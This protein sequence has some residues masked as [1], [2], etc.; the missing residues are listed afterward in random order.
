MPSASSGSVSSRV[1][2]LR[3]LMRLICTRVSCACFLILVHKS[4]FLLLISR[5]FA[6]ELHV[7]ILLAVNREFLILSFFVLLDGRLRGTF[8]SVASPIRSQY[9]IHV[10]LQFVNLT[11]LCFL[12][13]H[14]LLRVDVTA[15][16]LE[17]CAASLL[18]PKFF[19]LLRF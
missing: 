3:S 8:S 10:F 5:Y 9:K 15:L 7:D 1:L 4:A 2:L 12:S 14:V 19:L 11:N 17:K 13:R 6:C 16:V 18:S